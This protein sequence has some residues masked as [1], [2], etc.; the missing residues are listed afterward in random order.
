M[1]ESKKTIYQ[2]NDYTV[3]ALILPIY[4]QCFAEGPAHVA[5][6]YSIPSQTLQKAASP[7]LH[8]LLAR[9]VFDYLFDLT[10][11]CW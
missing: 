9:I 4:S 3:S 1:L 5:Q 11:Y 7:L 10:W 2:S 6:L 8:P